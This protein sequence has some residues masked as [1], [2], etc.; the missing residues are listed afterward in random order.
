MAKEEAAE[1]TSLFVGRTRDS[2]AARVGAS[3]GDAGSGGGTATRL[4]RQSVPKFRWRAGVSLYALAVLA[5]IVFS[6]ALLLSLDRLSDSRA[7]LYASR[8]TGSWVAFNAEL[9]Y[10]RFMTTLARYGLGEDGV[11][12]SELQRR[13]DILWSRIPLLVSGKDAERLRKADKSWDLEHDL[14]TALTTIERDIE[15]MQFGDREAYRRVRVV[16]DPFGERLRDLLVTVEIDLKQNFQQEIVESAYRQVFLSFMGVLVG[17]GGI[18]FLLFSQLRRIVRLSEAH[19]RASFEAEAANR[20][21][22]EFLARMTHELRTPLNA[23][24]GYS[25]LLQE[26]AADRGYRDMLEDLER[27]RTAGNHLL[28]MIN[29]TL[30]LAKI[31]TG[32]IE[33][34]P[35]S[36]EVN[37]LARE[38][39]EAVRPLIRKNRNKLETAIGDVGTAYTDPTK[40]RQIL[41]NLLSNAAKFTQDGVIRLDMDRESDGG[42]DWIRFRVGDTGL[43][44]PAQYQERVFQPFVQVDDSTTRSHGGS[45]LGLSVA[46]SLCTLMGGSIELE[47]LPK[48]GTTFSVSLPADI[49]AFTIEDDIELRESR[50]V[51]A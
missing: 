10:R 32:R 28:A 12:R 37:Q 7:A 40:L 14:T 43:G 36:V 8:A 1:Q 9:E 20:A 33:L 44:I 25:E 34:H 24:I 29:D 18:I 13:F 27:I 26:D 42:V 51:G 4:V 38:V 19:K 6:S 46:H 17:G 16:M 11:T 50:K 22:S 48:Q 45:G 2:D 41:F 47:S 15:T 49:T 31:E 3:Q 23:V 30:D 35:E 39:V 5:V 21:K